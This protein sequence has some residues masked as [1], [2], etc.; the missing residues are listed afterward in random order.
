VPLDRSGHDPGTI[1]LALWR[2][3]A[4]GDRI[5]ALLVNPGGPGAS[6][7]FLAAQ[8][9]DLFPQAIRDRFDIVAWDPRGTGESD[10]VD[11]GDHLDAFFAVDRDPHTQA[12]VQANITAARDLAAECARRSGRLLAHVATRDT[13]ADMDAIRAALGEAKLTYMGFS[14]GTYLG[15]RYALQYPDKVRAMVL[16]GAIDPEVSVAASTIQQSNGFE[17][18]LDSFLADCAQ[19]SSCAFHSGGDPRGALDN[20]LAA[21]AAEPEYAGSGRSLGPT[22]AR[23]GI[24]AALYSG[25]AAWS[26]LADA[27]AAAAGGDGS[28][29][30]KFSDDYTERSGDGTYSP[31]QAAFYATSCLDGQLPTTLSATRAL[32]DA[33]ARTAPVLGPFNAWLGLPCAYWPVKPVDGPGSVSAPPTLPTVVVIAGRNDPATP[34][35]W[36]QALARELRARLI[37]VDTEEH[38]AYVDGGPCVQSPVDDY[39]TSAT[40]PANDRSCTP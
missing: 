26:D 5:G 27:L 15:T 32:A 10:P 9:K 17:R 23:F 31:S 38:T 25:R 11:C 33:T 39:L 6:G 28:Q 29:L 21:V 18:D 13:V 24:V 37:S 34:Y 20:L 16:D 19:H 12:G 30:L 35:A 7:R 36:G 14:Y 22:E 2:H 1:R 8:A 4:E 40:P 3:P